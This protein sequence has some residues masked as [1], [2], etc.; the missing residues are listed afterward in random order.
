M[1]DLVNSLMSKNLIGIT[2]HLSPDGD[3]LGSALAL[4][5]GLRSFNK[6][7]YIIS[8]EKAPE[9]YGFLPSVHEIDG[10][11]SEVKENTDC[12][13]C[14]DCG[15]IERL[16]LHMKS[17]FYEIINIDHH[18][19]NDKYGDINYIDTKA[20]AVGEIIYSLLNKMNIEID[21]NIAACMYT[22]IVTDCGSFKYSNTTSNTHSIAGDLI[23]KGIDFSEIHRLIYENKK[24]DKIKLLGSVI[25]E[26]YLCLDNKVCMMEVNKKMLSE[27]NIE[28]ADTS[29]IISLGLEI[30]QVEIAILF[31]EVD[32][33]VKVSI[34]SKY[35]FDVRKI[36]EY[37]G[38]GGHK[39]ASGF[40]V[41]KPLLEAKNVVINLIEKEL[42]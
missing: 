39:K 27:L 36:A 10:N 32:D 38:G 23:S 11:T 30:D 42:I 28:Q 6:E 22:S 12:L 40:M 34:R 2:F 21:K 14:L 7:V 13:I 35:D 15:N 5:L 16:N 24:Y 37:F 41:F 33:G 4:M 1:N 9:E 26:M 18:L 20:S 31:K 3:S 8:K 25:N 29:G 17:K 19:S